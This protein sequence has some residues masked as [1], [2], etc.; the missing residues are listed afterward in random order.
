MAIKQRFAAILPSKNKRL[1]L[2]FNLFVLIIIALLLFSKQQL[3]PSL[4]AQI[5]SALF[6]L[7][8]VFI[9]SGRTIA[10]ELSNNELKIIRPFK[11]KIIPFSQIQDMWI[12]R[13]PHL[14]IKKKII[15]SGGLWGDYG[16]YYSDRYG[17]LKL[18]TTELNHNILL[19]TNA[20]QKLVL[21]PKEIV[22]FLD[23]FYLLKE[24]G[25]R[26]ITS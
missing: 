5:L 19:T 8:L 26:N 13:F 10:Y 2:F 22:A 9:Y 20:N 21:S 3:I 24:E 7:L 18:Y 15:A 1:T 16:T 11:N 14:Y 6:L 23:A 4:F 25:K 17:K 12:V